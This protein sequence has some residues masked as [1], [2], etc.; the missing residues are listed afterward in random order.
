MHPLLPCIQPAV[1]RPRYQKRA[2]HEED[3]SVCPIFLAKDDVFMAAT[4]DRYSRTTTQVGAASSVHNVDRAALIRVSPG[5]N[6]VED[7]KQA[8][9]PALS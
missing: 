5:L 3:G 8:L 2:K 1:Q 9:T 6:A 7:H 4:F